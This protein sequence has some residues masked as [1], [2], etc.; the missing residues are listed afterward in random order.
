[1]S[2]ES[3]IYQK[4]RIV[5]GLH[6]TKDAVRSADKV[7]IVE[8]Y[9]DL[10]SLYQSGMENVAAT[11]GTALTEDHARLI[12]RYARQAALIFDPDSAG[13]RAAMRGLEPL[14]A[15]DIWTQVIQLPDG[16][17]PDTY[18]RAEG[19]KAFLER[20]E[21]SNSIPE[22][23]AAQFDTSKNS[24]REEALKVL[25][26]IVNK[27]TNL[28]HRER[29]LEQAEQRLPIP[30]S[31]MAPLLR[32]DRKGFRD[33]EKPR[34]SSVKFEDPERELV[35][36]ML[37]DADVA[38][39]V[40]EQLH[41]SDFTNEMFASIVEKRIAS[42]DGDGPTDPAT[43]VDALSSEDA[44]QLISELI[45][46]EDT[47]TERDRRVWDYILRIKHTKIK[48]Q[49]EQLKGR[50]AQAE[51]VADGSIGAIMVEWQEVVKREQALL[52]APSPFAGE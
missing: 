34:T 10:L 21:Q 7:L 31:L 30:Q 12:G 3:P 23:I 43:L 26:G 48:L 5:Y 13:C 52:K 1:N 33:Y 8:G 47:G 19:S 14:V 22:F 2:P 20:I 37:S 32:A 25:A 50:I 17:D 46:I 45:V 28:R 44:T 27:A 4:S 6:Q 49:K 29:Y 9:M 42:L 16:Q 18:V 15:A 40:E 38:L 11:C 36:M 41:P 24:E 39:M 51:Q 35:R